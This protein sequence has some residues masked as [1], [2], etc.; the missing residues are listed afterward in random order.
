MVQRWVS[1]REEVSIVELE[2]GIRITVPGWMLDGVQ[3]QQL[4]QEARPRIAIEALVRLAELTGK[5]NGPGVEVPTKSN[6]TPLTQGK[7]AVRENLDLS[8]S[9]VAAGQ[10]RPLE[11]AAGT[12]ENPVP[13]TADAAHAVRGTTGRIHQPKEPR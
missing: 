3:C 12:Q 5:A 8:A 1:G 10:E 9:A 11:P 7:H 4:P 2:G 6:S 13:P